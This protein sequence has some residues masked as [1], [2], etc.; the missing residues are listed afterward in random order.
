MAKKKSDDKAQAENP[1]VHKD[2]NGFDIKINSFGEIQM[3]FEIDKI[4]SFLNNTVDDKKL[5]NRKKDTEQ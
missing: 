1:R 2:L 5:R 3:S 4:N